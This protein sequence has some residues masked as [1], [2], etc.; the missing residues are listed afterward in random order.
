[1]GRNNDKRNDELIKD[2]ELPSEDIPLVEDD[3]KKSDKM[4]LPSYLANFSKYRNIDHVIISW[5]G[6]NK[7]NEVKS[8]KE[9]I[10]L[11]D[12]FFN[13]KDGKK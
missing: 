2:E 6:L 8:K 3:K 4:T 7:K 12:K 1:M 11:V 10:D 9:W 5:Y 13:E